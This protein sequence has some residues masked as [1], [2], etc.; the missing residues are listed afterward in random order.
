MNATTRNRLRKRKLRI[1]GRLADFSRED[2]GEPVLAATNI[3]YEVAG[4]AGAVTCG[5]LGAIHM[6][7]RRSGL[8]DAIDRDLH[9]LKIHRPY[10]ESD[11][12]LIHRRCV[13]RPDEHQGILLHRLGLNLPSNLPVTDEKPTGM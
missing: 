1:R 6:L 4:R 7:A 5:G 13:T 11:H 3:H 2:R 9:L 8:V 10:Q 12:V